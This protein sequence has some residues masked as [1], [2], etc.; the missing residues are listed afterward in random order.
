[1]LNMAE[2]DTVTFED[3][4]A[5]AVALHGDGEY[6][7]ALALSTDAYDMAPDATFEKGRAARDNGARCDRLGRRGEALQWALAAYEV[8][9]NLVREVGPTRGALRER[10]VSAMYVAV[11]GLRREV[12]AKRE[13]VLPT[14]PDRTTLPATWQTW[15]DLQAAKKQASGINRWVDQYEINAARRVSIVESL[16]D[17]RKR[18]FGIG[19]RAVGLAFMSESP[20]LDTSNPNLTPRQRTRAKSKAFVGGLA[21]VAVGVLASP[22]PNRR[23]RAAY[24]LA[25]RIV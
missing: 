9:D 15:S 19:L 4:M 17:N 3:F 23:Q 8:H 1:M 11:H 14:D 12:Q 7:A 2:F 20:R 10:S 6:E 18:G 16:M 5:R 21:A 24:E 13:G 25:D 22:H